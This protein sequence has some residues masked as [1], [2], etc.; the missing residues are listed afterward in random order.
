M[1]R[2]GTKLLRG[3]LNNH[4]E[5]AIPS[6]ETEFLPYLVNKWGNQPLENYATFLRFYND[7]I[8]LPYFFYMK[9]ENRLIE[10][11]KWY[12]LCHS[13]SPSGIFEALIRHDAKA[14]R[15]WGDK[16]PSYILQI[17]LIKKLFPNAKIIHIIRDVR[18]HCLSMHHAWGKNMMRAAQRWTDNISLSKN[19]AAFFSK[20]CIEIK[21]ENL[22]ET[23]EKVVKKVCSFLGLEYTQQML[24]LT[25]PTEE[26]GAA[27]GKDIILR[28]NSKKYLSCMD[29]SVKNRIDQL[30][31]ELLI[32]LNYPC[33]Y[34][35]DTRR[36]NATILFF[37]KIIDGIQ[38]IRFRMRKMGVF[39]SILFYL[40]SQRQQR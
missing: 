40:N 19:D 11:Q 4:P 34:T 2:S 23:P 25:H 12:H 28:D 36:L 3:I 33:D 30:C 22:I 6:F 16:S 5:I 14:S 10:A 38:L 9:E 37:L 15:I 32:D 20:D 7:M 21:Y 1:P 31:A 13:Y 27:K 35:G 8:K 29:S 17:P 26:I 24:I 39:N 18:D